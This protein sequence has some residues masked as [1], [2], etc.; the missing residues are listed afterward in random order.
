[1]TVL[2][3]TGNNRIDFMIDGNVKNIGKIVFSMEDMHI[4]YSINIGKGRFLIV[5]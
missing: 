1:M 4:R 3:T 5:E 2:I